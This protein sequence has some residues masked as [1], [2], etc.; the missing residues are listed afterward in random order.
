MPLPYESMMSWISMWRGLSMNFSMSIRS[1]PKEEAASDLE[2]KK[3][4]TASL[5]F[6]A[7]RRPCVEADV[8]S[9]FLHK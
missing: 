1:S 6:H 8:N 5:S 4:S 7:I 2:R 9:F 3:L